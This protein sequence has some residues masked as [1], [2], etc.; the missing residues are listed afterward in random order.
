MVKLGLEIKDDGK[1]VK[2]KLIDPTKKQLEE[3]TENEKIVAQR[4]KD[5]FD[6]SLIELLNTEE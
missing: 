2:I 4:V 6:I 5:V 1:E 3:A